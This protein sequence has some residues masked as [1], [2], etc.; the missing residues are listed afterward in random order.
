MPGRNAANDEASNRL[1]MLGSLGQSAW[2]DF[3]DRAFL[4][5]GGLAR[6]VERDGVS[7]VTSNPVDL[8]EG[9]HANVGL[10]SAAP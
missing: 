5:S 10:R 2:L 3:I 1:R 6:L 7:G 4:A 9:D 8:R